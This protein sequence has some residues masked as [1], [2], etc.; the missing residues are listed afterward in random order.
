MGSW[1]QWLSQAE[2]LSAAMIV[3]ISNHC[4]HKQKLDFVDLPPPTSLG[5]T[6]RRVVWI[7]GASD[8][9]P[10]KGTRKGSDFLL[11][12]KNYGIESISNALSAEDVEVLRIYRRQVELALRKSIKSS[13]GDQ[14]PSIRIFENGL[15]DSVESVVDETGPSTS[16]LENLQKSINEHGLPLSTLMNRAY[17]WAM[18]NSRPRLAK[19]LQ[20]E[21][22]GRFPTM[23][24]LK[25]RSKLPGYRIRSG[26]VGKICNGQQVRA[27]PKLSLIY[28][29]YPLVFGAKEIENLLSMAE[30]KGREV[31]DYY[32]E[33]G[34]MLAIEDPSIEGI[35]IKYS[36]TEFRSLL[37]GIRISLMKFISN[38]DDASVELVEAPPGGYGRVALLSA[39]LALCGGMAWKSYGEFDNPTPA[40]ATPPNLTCS[41]FSSEPSGTAE[42]GE[43]IT[44]S[45]KFTQAR[46]KTQDV[47]VT[48]DPGDR[49]EV[50]REQVRISEHSPTLRTFFRHLYNSEGKFKAFVTIDAANAV[51]ETNETDNIGIIDIQVRTS[52][53]DI[54][55]EMI[56]NLKAY[57]NL[58]VSGD[59]SDGTEDTRDKDNSGDTYTSTT[60]IESIACE[61]STL[62]SGLIR[63][64]Y[65]GL[66]E[67][68]HFIY[69]Y[70]TRGPDRRQNGTVRASYTLD[71]TNRTVHVDKVEHE[72]QQERYLGNAA[73][74]E[75]RLL[76]D[77]HF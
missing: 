58:N 3:V 12:V 37:D 41:E 77:K 42:K 24:I 68:T 59:M 22:N 6:T 50:V 71:L 51:D 60:E 53:A 11:A 63:V 74:Q 21:L 8:G 56:N 54:K 47:V 32:P 14:V 57:L 40:P 36:V 49:S 62:T 65:K 10:A 5:N 35:V 69:G 33:S 18:N 9:Q 64:K 66:I 43:L 34:L 7:T 73:M 28:A 20:A 19:W 16:E 67:H 17:V 29:N 4:R 15:E 31:I 26:P 76:D 45:A 46:A 2:N 72:G 55:T 75:L 39:A 52:A 48:F 44:F 13:G 61:E 27:G 23:S 38:P 25:L 30:Q 1:C 70:G